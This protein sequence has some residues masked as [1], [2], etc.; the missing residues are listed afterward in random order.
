MLNKPRNPVIK[1]SCIA[2]LLA[3][4]N[5][6]A[7]L[8][9]ASNYDECVLDSMKGVTSD[10]AA[11]AIMKSC[12]DKFAA[13]GPTPAPVPANVLQALEG[14][15]EL[16]HRGANFMGNIYNG[17]P[18]WTIKTVTIRLIGK[19][20]PKNPAGAK[21][22]DYTLQIDATPLTNFTFFQSIGGGEFTNPD[23]QIIGASGYRK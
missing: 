19:P 1:A 23:W 20:D 12:K 18:D 15:G 13:K 22:R 9:G 8:F 11:R 5:S 16:D 17:S 14:R 10:V 2:L 3:V 21:S 7:G 6:H 4:T